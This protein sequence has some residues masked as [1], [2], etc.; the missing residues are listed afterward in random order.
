[1]KCVAQMPKPAAAASKAEPDQT[2]APLRELR[3]MKEADS[4]AACQEANSHS[5][6]HQAP[7]VPRS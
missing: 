4:D 6:Q 7:V 2:C 3:A 5:E 1:M